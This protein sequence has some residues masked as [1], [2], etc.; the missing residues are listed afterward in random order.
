MGFTENRKVAFAVLAVCVLISVIGFG[1][2]GLAR[3]RGRVLTVYDRGTD[4]SMST[5]HSMDA[6]LDHSAEAAQLMVSEAGLHIDNAQVM[7][8]VSSLAEQVAKETDVAARYAAYTDLKTAV[9]KLYDAVYKAV[10]GDGFKNFK[11]AYDDFRGYD[12]MIRHDDYHK[13]A[14]D[15]NALASGFPGGI[16]GSIT[17]QGKLHPFEG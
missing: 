1:G 7:D 8:N 12:D 10:Q 3:E 11:V 15:Y 13:L 16:V 14:A 17:G 6:Y 4:A 2:M 5:R 9:D